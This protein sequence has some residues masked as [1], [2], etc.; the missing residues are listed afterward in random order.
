M[1]DTV[2]VY[3]NASPPPPPHRKK[4]SRKRKGTRAKASLSAMLA[5]LVFCSCGL[6]LLG[7]ISATLGGILALVRPNVAWI[8]PQ[9]RSLS[10]EMRDPLQGYELSRPMN[11]L[12]V[13]I[14]PDS[15]AQNSPE[16]R[17][18]NSDLMVLMRFDPETKSVRAL[19]IPPQTR[20]KI[21]QRGRATIAEAN[22]I[23]GIALTAR[24][25]SDRLNGVAIDRYIR[26]NSQG[27]RQG[28]DWLG[29]VEMNLAESIP[30][31]QEEDSVSENRPP[32]WETLTGLRALQFV[33]MRDGEA[34]GELERVQRQQRFLKGL[35]HRLASPRVAPQLERMVRLMQEYVDT[36]LSAEEM[37]A[38]V[39]LARSRSP[40]GL[41]M[42]LLPGR[43]RNADSEE[44]R[45]WTI[46]ES[47]RDRLIAE[48]FLPE[49]RNANTEESAED[50]SEAQR[51][52]KRVKIAVQNASRDPLAVG[53]LVNSLKAQGLEKVYPVAPSP[54]T[55]RHTEIIAQN[56]DFAAASALQT[57]L[58][59]GRI[60]VSF[61]GELGSEMTIRIGDDW[62]EASE[63][64]LLK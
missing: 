14:H 17:T 50:S 58:T 57:L 19:W 60:E 1:F 23:G 30:I 47:D 22:R 49:S 34:D 3:E 12:L 56:G 37:L 18:E 8:G 7:S 55:Q 39:N 35:R 31:V 33:G 26:L 13:G 20:V 51:S 63:S 6:L 54:Q 53:Q 52:L 62:L 27:F 45:Q 29:G 32:G 38:L 42:V 4:K 28:V 40:E 46:D 43:W 15:E 21:P 59:T 11:V 2:E 5:R 64:D 44:N 10:Q 9:A 36:N 48:Y 41:K 16:W 24:L 25:V 61:T